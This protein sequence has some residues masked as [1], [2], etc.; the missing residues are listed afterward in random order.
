MFVFQQK[1]MKKDQRQIPDVWF[2]HY[3]IIWDFLQNKKR[4]F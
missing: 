2:N 1:L 3:Q 4:F